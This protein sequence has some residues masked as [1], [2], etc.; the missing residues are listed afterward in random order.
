MK[1][2]GESQKKPMK[3]GFE[4]IAAYNKEDDKEQKPDCVQAI[5]S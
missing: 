1:C 3:V 4:P 5:A 2:D